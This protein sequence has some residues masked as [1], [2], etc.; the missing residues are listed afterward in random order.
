MR[1]SILNHL[2]HMVDENRA[3]RTRDISTKAFP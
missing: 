2:L 1:K 3:Y